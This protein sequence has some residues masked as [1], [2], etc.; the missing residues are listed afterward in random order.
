MQSPSRCLIGG[1]PPC[2]PSPFPP[3]S[4]HLPAI[5]S[6]VNPKGGPNRGSQLRSGSPSVLRGV[7]PDLAALEAEHSSRSRPASWCRRACRLAGCRARIPRRRTARVGLR[8]S[9]PPSSRWVSASTFTPPSSPCVPTSPTPATADSAGAAPPRTG[10]TGSPSAYGDTHTRAQCE[11]CRRTRC[12]SSPRGPT[13]TSVWLPRS[14]CRVTC[15]AP[16]SP[17][18]ASSG[19]CV[20]SACSPSVSPQSSVARRG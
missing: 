17:L 7:H 9:R 3:A 8:A 19:A 16:P 13:S 12:S 18:P 11:G 10:H 1:R 20:L 15:A 2:G 14:P 6:R 4:T 5:K